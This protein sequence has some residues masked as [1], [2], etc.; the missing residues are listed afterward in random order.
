MRQAARELLHV[1]KGHPMTELF[2]TTFIHRFL[3]SI[4]RKLLPYYQ[5]GP[6]GLKSWVNREVK[7]TLLE[8]KSHSD[9]LAKCKKILKK[10]NK[11]Q[12]TGSLLGHKH[13]RI[14]THGT[15]AVF[16]AIFLSK[17]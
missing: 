17:F 4:S 2:L 5:I 3:K 10:K 11:N 6:Q 16:L 14:L 7:I 9:S 8:K 15:A 12:A 13:K 1:C